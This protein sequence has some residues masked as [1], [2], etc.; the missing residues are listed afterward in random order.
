MKFQRQS[1]SSRVIAILDLTSGLLTLF[2]KLIL[3]CN[4]IMKV[5]NDKKSIF[6]QFIHIIKNKRAIFITVD[7]MFLLKVLTINK[8]KN[9]RHKYQ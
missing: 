1:L 9:T 7:S 6:S 2:T 4:V 5:I 8:S 3:H